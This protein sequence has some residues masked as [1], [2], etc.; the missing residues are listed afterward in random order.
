VNIKSTVFE[1]DKEDLLKEFYQSKVYLKD[2]L[3]DLILILS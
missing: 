3:R 2:N 1:G